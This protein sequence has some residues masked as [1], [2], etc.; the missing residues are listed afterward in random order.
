MPDKKQD[1][2]G[3][4][5]AP[6]A[7][8][9]KEVTQPLSPELLAKQA[10]IA[11]QN[12]VLLP[13]PSPPGGGKP[14]PFPSP[15][16]EGV[17]LKPSAAAPAPAPAPAVVPGGE[18]QGPSL[19]KADEVL[20]PGGGQTGTVPLPISAPGDGPSPG[21]AI[22]PG[23]V[24]AVE[25]VTPPAPHAPHQPAASDTDSPSKGQPT[26]IT[27]PGKVIT[28]GWGTPTGSQYFAL[29]GDELRVLVEDLMTRLRTEMQAD[30][31]FSLALTYPQV[32]A[33]VTVT[34]DGVSPD[35]GVNDVRF[36]LVARA[37]DTQDTPPDYHRDQTGLVKP[38]KRQVGKQGARPIL[39]DL[40]G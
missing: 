9:P 15:I 8:A 26:P 10:A 11:A 30:L 7:H 21:P 28:G 19:P 4:F 5:G 40:P 25:S 17:S 23:G 13:L 1:A 36:E 18:V 32:R 22:P 3:S 6:P 14:M 12:E 24:A 29:N 27:D 37:A 33:T 16:P 31:R 34:I 20:G 38:Y 2:T 39:A 35:A